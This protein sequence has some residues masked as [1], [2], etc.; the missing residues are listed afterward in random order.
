MIVIKIN[1][2]TGLQPRAAASLLLSLITAVEEVAKGERK[3]SYIRHLW[4]ER[5]NKG[6]RRMLLQIL[7][8]IHTQLLPLI[9]ENFKPIKESL[10][11][12]EIPKQAQK[13]LFAFRDSIEG[14]STPAKVSHQ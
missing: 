9:E 5:L 12:V 13:I 2:P 1:T 3:A 10:S 8:Q 7:S 6:E 4:R 11:E 14:I